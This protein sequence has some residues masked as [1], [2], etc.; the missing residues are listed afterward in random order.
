MRPYQ[1]SPSGVSIAF[2]FLMRVSVVVV[3]PLSWGI[4]LVALE[5]FSVLSRMSERREQLPSLVSSAPRSLLGGPRSA[6]SSSFKT[7]WRG[8]VLLR[9]G[10]EEGRPRAW[11]RLVVE[12]GH[13]VA[14]E[15]AGA[16]HR[17]QELAPPDE[18]QDSFKLLVGEHLP[19]DLGLGGRP[20]LRE[21]GISKN[22]TLGPL[23]LLGPKLQ[24]QIQEPL[25]VSIGK[26]HPL[27]TPL[28]APGRNRTYGIRFRK[29]AFYPLNYGGRGLVSP[30]RLELAT[31]RFVAVRS[32]H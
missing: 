20:G 12:D 29:S 3:P 27:L 9:E 5:P 19:R 32:I 1:S 31:S 13:P 7:G 22:L 17:S 25:T 2:S 10:Q 28:C 30:A 6:S 26:D 23:V 18:T 8:K 24:V 14:S 21:D 11:E 4:H 16:E 15:H